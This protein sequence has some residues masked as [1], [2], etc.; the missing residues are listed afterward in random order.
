MGARMMQYYKYVNDEK[1]LLGKIDLA[2][3][4]KIPSAKAALEPDSD[5][6]IKLFR[7]AVEEITGKPAPVY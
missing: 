4:T 1:G 5:D 2:K 6:N 7:K 3:L